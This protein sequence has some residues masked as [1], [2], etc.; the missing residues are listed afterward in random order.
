MPCAAL[1][2]SSYVQGTDAVNSDPRTLVAPEWIFFE[3]TVYGEDQP[4]DTR[5][6]LRT[7]VHQ[8]FDGAGIAT[9]L[10]FNLAEIIAKL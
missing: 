7:R 5:L 3:Q 2:R 8:Y 4:S 10:A 1:Y 9:S 6:N